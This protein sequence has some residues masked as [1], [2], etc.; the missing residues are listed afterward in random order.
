MR[1]PWEAPTPSI[2]STL[3]FCLHVD[4]QVYTEWMTELAQKRTT[5]RIKAGDSSLGEELSQREQAS[6]GRKSGIL[7]LLVESA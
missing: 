3:F 1:E 4:T 2:N 7:Q 6:R 5:A